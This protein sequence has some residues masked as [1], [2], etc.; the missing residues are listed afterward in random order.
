MFDY[1]KKSLFAQ[2]EMTFFIRKGEK[3]LFHRNKPENAWKGRIHQGM[4]GNKDFLGK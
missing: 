1:L 4:Y 2:I 3:T